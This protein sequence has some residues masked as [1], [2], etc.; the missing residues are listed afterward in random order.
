[1]ASLP[2]GWKLK[3]RRRPKD[4]R[5]EVV[6]KDDA[7]QEYVARTC[8]G[9]HV[10]EQ[11]LQILAVG[12]RENSTAREVV[13]FYEKQRDDYRKNWE[14]SLDSEYMDGADKVVHAGLHLSESRAG[15]SRAYAQAFERLQQKGNI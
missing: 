4:G 3:A 6:G 8:E 15:Y 1:M 12:N 5:C 13:R 9:T 7:G 2:A 10:T 11:D 14:K